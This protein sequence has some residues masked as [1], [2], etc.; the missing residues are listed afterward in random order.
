MK[1]QDLIQT[2][3]KAA[4]AAGGEASLRAMKLGVNALAGKTLVAQVI[5]GVDVDGDG[6]PDMLRA[7]VRGSIK[8]GPDGAPLFT[9]EG[10][11]VMP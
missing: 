6:E 5:V 8:A 1:P 3:L 2:I 9:L 7:E 11:R 4:V 10:L